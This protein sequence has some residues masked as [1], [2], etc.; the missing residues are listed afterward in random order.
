MIDRKIKILL[1]VRWPVVGIRT[2]MRYVY[3]NFDPHRYTFT[4]LAPAT[5]EI[6]VLLDDLSCHNILFIPMDV[7]PSTYS[8]ATTIFTTLYNNKHDIIHSHGLTAGLCS[9]L[10]SYV[11][12]TPHLLTLH[13]VFTYKQFQ[14]AKGFF[15]RIIISLVMPLIDKIHTV[16][17]D[18]KYNLLEYVFT[19]KLFKAKVVAIRNGI[20]I[21]RFSHS[22]SKDLRNELNLDNN[23]FLIGF[24]G[25]FMSQKGFIYLVEALDIL[26]KNGDLKSNPV[27]LTFGEGAYI[28][29]EKSFVERKGLQNVIH[30][31]PFAPNIAPILKGL[32]VVVMPSLWEACGL[33]AMEAMVVGTPLIGTDCI[34]L[35]EIIDGTPCKKVPIKNSDELAKAIAQEINNPSKNEAGLFRAE[36]RKRFNVKKHFAE[37][38]KVMENLIKG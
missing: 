6:P 12:Q 4:L 28:R 2:Y 17:V 29:E 34:G 21:E 37:L 15:K 24:L 18:A 31:M 19:L 14:G 11:C 33:L 20:E 30:F 38:E 26:Y 7:N 27:I 3:N 16:T 1:V 36:A 8:F 23:T 25:R 35:R 32:D 9:I 13:D 5:S 22:E 10:P